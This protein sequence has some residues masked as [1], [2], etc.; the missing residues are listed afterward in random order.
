MMTETADS[1]WQGGEA[2]AKRV[3]GGGPPQVP[4]E[5]ETMAEMDDDGEVSG[6]GGDASG[7]QGAATA[8]AEQ[9]EDE[10]YIEN[11]DPTARGGAL[12]DS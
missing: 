12:G 5:D 6:A 7:G 3:G 11:R 8:A 9:V 2:M 10:V 4:A 1:S